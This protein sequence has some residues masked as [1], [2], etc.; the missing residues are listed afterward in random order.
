LGTFLERVRH[1]K[2]Q[3]PRHRA[4][5]PAVWRSAYETLRTDNA[6]DE[7]F[8][9]GL[10]FHARLPVLWERVTQAVKGL[11]RPMLLRFLCGAATLESVVAERELLDEAKRRDVARPFAHSLFQQKIAVA[12]ETEVTADQIFSCIGDAFSLGLD[13]ALRAGPEAGGDPSAEGSERT[14]MSMRELLLLFQII[15][16]LEHLWGAA[17]ISA[18]GLSRGR[19]KPSFGTRTAPSRRRLRSPITNHDHAK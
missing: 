19:C 11:S 16:L 6:D 1:G 4:F 3:Q 18:C 2:L 7:L 9:A 8:E 10:W 5:D 12:S 17:S 15:G 13:Y 14:G